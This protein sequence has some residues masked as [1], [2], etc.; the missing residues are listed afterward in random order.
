VTTTHPLHTDDP[1]WRR[2]SAR[3]LLGQPI[4]ELVRAAPALLG[5]LV[6][7]SSSG[8]GSLWSLVGVAVVIALGML[9]WLTT[10]YRVTA[11][12]VQVR[13][14]LLRRR[15]LSI[16]RDRVRTVDVTADVMH[17]FLGLARV[18]VGTG[19][20]DR[21]DDGGLRLDALRAADAARLREEL[22]HRPAGP[23]VA[24]AAGRPEVAPPET[25]LAALRPAWIAYGPFT[26]S[27]VVTVAVV[28]GFLSQLVTEAHLDPARFR[29][30]RELGGQLTA[31]P[32]WLAI[33]EVLLAAVVLVTVAS[34]AGY[35]LAFWRFRLTRHRGGTLHVTRGLVTT[36]AT[37][38]EERRLRGVEVSEPLLLRAVGGARCIAIATGLRV[39]HGAER[40]GSLL[41]P[42]APY[43][44]AQ[45]VAAAVLGA[46][47]PVTGRLAAHGRRA[48]RRRCT[49]ALLPSAL[50]V[51]LLGLLWRRAGL[52]AWAWLAS[53]ALLPCAL[54]VALDRYRSLGHAILQGRLVS[55]WGCLV[56]R[57]CVLSCEG[58][59]GWD[60]YQSFF[61]RR[62]GLATLTATTA[63]GR[64]HYRVQDLG[65]DQ[66]VRLAN[67]AVPGLLAPFLVH[68]RA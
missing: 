14:G 33:A 15:A 53:L 10:R 16:P 8:H 50:L 21:K 60:L 38:I 40:G 68:G 59:I 35:V 67:Q 43:A 63:A 37:T 23:G 22:L 36:R 55:R 17:R 39:G 12:Q 49:R 28:G 45:R 65:V 7:G 18:T 11:E 9:R 61:Q 4:R 62:A 64:Q 31:A 47:A 5:L 56:R 34:T 2:L 48:L 52:P 6:A 41:L 30:L 25:E 1:G 13:H 54:L 27:G 57:R 32:L 19:R 20:S 46:Q 3:M 44:Q 26:L 24:A 66:A 42:P 51:A 29:P 58:I